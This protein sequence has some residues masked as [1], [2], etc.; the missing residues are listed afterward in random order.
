MKNRQTIEKD[1]IENAKLK[2]AFLKR[3]PDYQASFKKLKRNFKIEDD[4]LL[5]N[6]CEDILF[7][8][9][10]FSIWAAP[11][12]SLAADEGALLDILDP[13]KEIDGNQY[14]WLLF[15]MF[16]FEGIEEIKRPDLQLFRENPH[17]I[18]PKDLEDYE[19]LLKV[20]LRKPKE[21][22]L[23]EFKNFL[24]N[25]YTEKKNKVVREHIEDRIP[26][27]SKETI[28]SWNAYQKRKLKSFKSWEPDNSRSRKEAWM[29][30]K[31][32][33][34]YGT[35]LPQ[36]DIKKRKRGFKYVA[37]KLNITVDTA[38]QAYRKAFERIY[39]E[40]YNLEAMQR[41]LSKIRQSEADLFG[42]CK[43]CPNFDTCTDPCPKLLAIIDQDEHKRKERCI[44][45]IRIPEDI[46]DP[47]GW[48]NLK[49]RK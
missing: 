42:T 7:R 24:D 34:L 46:E 39:H 6:D 27:L 40:P 32:W 18:N 47:I 16:Y 8:E 13:E 9:M 4:G 17:S 5:S 25:T 26:G 3:H 22:L 21:F 38:R 20:D 31:V 48:L 49:N 11:E 23:K 14:K 29:Q 35:E 19:R 45:E 1:R 28:K 30:I 44:S 2:L 37:W 36:S 15:F 41:V 33:D 10:G 12:L 43:N